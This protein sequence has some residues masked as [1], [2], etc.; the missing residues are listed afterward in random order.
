MKAYMQDKNGNIY[1]TTLNIA[2]ARDGRNILYALSNTKKIDAGDVPS[3]QKL[4]GARSQIVN[5]NDSIISHPDGDVKPDSLKRDNPI[6]TKRKA[7]SRIQKE[8]VEQQ[9]ENTY[10]PFLTSETLLLIPLP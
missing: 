9:T 3:T 10:S 8:A 5:L 2:K 6:S 4:R 1:E 7:C